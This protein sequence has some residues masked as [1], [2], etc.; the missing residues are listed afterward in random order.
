MMAKEHCKRMEVLE[1]QKELY[2]IQTELAKKQLE[3]EE[4][5]LRYYRW[6]QSYPN[7]YQNP[8]NH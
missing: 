8:N 7:C 4:E 3:A 6:L 1:K 5:R 2:I